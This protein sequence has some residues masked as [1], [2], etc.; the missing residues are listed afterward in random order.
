MTENLFE[1]EAMACE[2]QLMNCGWSP[3]ND[4]TSIYDWCQIDTSRFACHD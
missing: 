4:P 1:T 3:V 2:L